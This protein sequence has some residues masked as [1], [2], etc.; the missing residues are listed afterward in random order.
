MAGPNK[1]FGT[2]FAEYV[3]V[4]ST[5]GVKDMEIGSTGS[6]TIALGATVDC[7]ATDI[8]FAYADIGDLDIVSSGSLDIAEGATIDCDA[9]DVSLSHADIENLDIVSAGSLDIAASAT[10][11]CDSTSVSLTG[12]P[13][14]ADQAAATTAGLTTSTVYQTSAGALR[15]VI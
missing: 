8:S 9:T 3:T 11:G 13:E 4:E 15:I 2:V 10:I 5:I 14:Y 7:D 12:L 6:L 1:Q